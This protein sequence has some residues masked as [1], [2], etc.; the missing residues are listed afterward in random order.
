[1]SSLAGAFGGALRETRLTTMLGY[2]MALEPEP[3]CDIFAFH[4]RPLSVRKE[5][6]TLD[7]TV[8][9]ILTQL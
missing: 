3:V 9:S 7:E 5:A 6:G 8:D 2:V 1:V 4:G